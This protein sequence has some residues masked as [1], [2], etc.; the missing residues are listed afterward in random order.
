[1]IFL[2][3]IK[4]NTHHTLLIS[5]GGY[6]V[7][8]KD[9]TYNAFLAAANRGYDG[10]KCDIRF[11]KDN[12]I[13]TS[14]YR[15]L[16]NLTG[17]KIHVSLNNYQDLLKLPILNDSFTHLST[18]NEFLNLCKKYHKM[19]IIELRPPIGHNELKQLINLIQSFKLP[20]VKIIANDIKYLKFIRTLNLDINLEL[21]SNEYNDQLFLN[22][23]KYRFDL[24]L[25]T[26]F[27][28]QL[29]VD[30]CHENKIKL[31]AKN[32][33]NFIDAQIL[34]ELGIDYIYT[35]SLEK[36]NDY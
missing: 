35:Y 3:N 18:L 36:A 31:A 16:K 13:I 12:Y 25:P 10:I 30:F 29:F 9:N 15:D 17:K 22:A 4:I 33:N 34:I 27:Y 2:Q 11:T 6:L 20:T 1:M 26:K 24:N 8:E 28:N 14:R 19:P 7:L 23:I 5:D 21:I 32:I